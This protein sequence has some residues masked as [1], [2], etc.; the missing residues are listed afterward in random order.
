MTRG[1]TEDDGLGK[2]NPFFLKE[3][4][5]F[6][7]S[8]KHCSICMFLKYIFNT[9]LTFLLQNV[10]LRFQPNSWALQDFQY[11]WTN[12]NF[13]INCTHERKYKIMHAATR[14]TGLFYVDNIQGS[15]SEFIQ[16]HC[17]QHLHIKSF[18]YTHTSI[19]NSF[20]MTIPFWTRVFPFLHIREYIVCCL[21]TS[22]VFIFSYLL[23][24]LV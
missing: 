1:F 12:K 20:L 3:Q 8:L 13:Q 19:F 2:L 16:L 22:I 21:F 23:Y 10:Y 15:F 24:F 9:L 6:S 18:Y 5:N 14:K 11:S 4:S 7:S 17:F